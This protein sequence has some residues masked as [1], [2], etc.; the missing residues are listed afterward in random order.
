MPA[1]DEDRG[2][3]PAVARIHGDFSSLKILGSSMGRWHLHFA[4]A[5]DGDGFV[6]DLEEGGEL[7]G[8]AVA[9]HVD[10]GGFVGGVIY[11]VAVHPARRGQGYGKLLVASAEEEL[12]VRGASVLIA[13]ISGDNHVSRRLFSSMGYEILSWDD[14]AGVC[15]R[16]VLESLVMATCGY[17]D[18]LVALKIWGGGGLEILCRID[19]A[20][21]RRWWR[22]KCLAPWLRLRIS[23]P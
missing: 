22:S 12:L 2:S 15:G 4:R 11:Y 8:Q 7:V 5:V 1:S 23:S 19:R 6:V 3:T 16:E 17:E 20:R 21:A 14:V 18:D 10:L 13:T 9:Y